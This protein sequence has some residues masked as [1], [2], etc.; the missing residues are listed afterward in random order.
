MKNSRKVGEVS[1]VD[2]CEQSMVA[3]IDGKDMFQHEVVKSK[4]VIDAESDDEDE[5][6][7]VI[8]GESE[9]D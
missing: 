5:L 8:S 2:G 6:A 1:P 3:K 7:D 9:G 4:G